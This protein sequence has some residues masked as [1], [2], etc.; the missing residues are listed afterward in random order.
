MGVSEPDFQADCLENCR[1]HFPGGFSPHFLHSCFLWEVLSALISCPT[2]ELPKGVSEISSP[3]FLVAMSEE[4]WSVSSSRS[5][6]SQSGTVLEELPR[7]FGSQQSTDLPGR[8]MALN[9]CLL[10]I[11]FPWPTEL[12][13]DFYR[14]P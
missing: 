11:L 10:F 6:E 3:A 13:R 2:A 4:R 9:F 5:C 14:I 12:Q 8:V 7:G 1:L